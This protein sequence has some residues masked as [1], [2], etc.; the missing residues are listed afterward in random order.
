MLFLSNQSS[1][2]ISFGLNLLK[3]QAMPFFLQLLTFSSYKLDI[4]H[5]KYKTKSLWKLTLGLPSLYYLD[6]WYNCQTVNK[7]L[8]SLLG[9][10][11]SPRCRAVFAVET[12]LILYITYELHALYELSNSY[13]SYGLRNS[14]VFFNY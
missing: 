7:F 3:N 11:T 12:S 14:Y 1:I 5:R 8:A 13:N 4:I 6:I 2:K 10:R 9:L